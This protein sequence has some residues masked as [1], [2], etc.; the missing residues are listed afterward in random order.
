MLC[1]GI[2]FKLISVANRWASSCFGSRIQNV[3]AT[4]QIVLQLGQNYSCRWVESNFVAGFKI[5]L[6]WEPEQFASVG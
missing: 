1:C 2:V 5:V 4:L 6:P 3:L